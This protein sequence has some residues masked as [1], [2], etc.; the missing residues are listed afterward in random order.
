MVQETIELGRKKAESLKSLIIREG[1]NFF[2]LD[3]EGMRKELNNY[4]KKMEE[5]IANLESSTKE[6]Y[7]KDLHEYFTILMR[8]TLREDLEVFDL[9]SKLDEILFQVIN[10]PQS[11]PANYN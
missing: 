5:D 10:N 7:Y 6:V 3:Y 11:E 9:A 2:K 4:K 1:T 8:D